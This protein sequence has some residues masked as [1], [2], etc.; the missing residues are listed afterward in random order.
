[1]KGNTKRRKLLL[2][3]SLLLISMLVLTSCASIRDLIATTKGELIGNHFNIA[4][5]DNYANKTLAMEGRKVSISTLEQETDRDKDEAKIDSSVLEL[6]INGKQVIQVGNTMIFAEDGLSMVEDFEMPE[7]VNVESGGFFVPADRY[8]NSIKN[9][10]GAKKT[11]IVL[12]PRGVP[13]GVFQ[14]N[15]V[16]VTV[17]KDLPKMTRLNIDGKSLYIH[18]ANYMILDTDAMK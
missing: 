14:G 13:I 5:Y 12:T 15:K 16:Y 8:I 1:M 7:E 6:T 9:K 11:I 18:R 3:S 2:L 17:P 10:I 4:V